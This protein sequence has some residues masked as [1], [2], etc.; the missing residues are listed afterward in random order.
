LVEATVLMCCVLSFWLIWEFFLK[1]FFV[2]MMDSLLLLELWGSGVSVCLLQTFC[3]QIY[4]ALLHLKCWRAVIV[5]WLKK[6]HFFGKRVCQDIIWQTKLIVRSVLILWFALC[7]FLAKFFFLIN[8]RVISMACDWYFL[9][10]HL[11][12]QLQLAMFLHFFCNFVSTRV[13]LSLSLFWLSW[14]LILLCVW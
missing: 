12:S 5:Q 10:L 3:T 8:S 2:C 7:E 9:G 6:S 1:A 4:C 14:C 13:P 11:E